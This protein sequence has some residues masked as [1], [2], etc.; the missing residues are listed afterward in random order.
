MSLTEYLYANKYRRALNDDSLKTYQKEKV[1]WNYRNY[2]KDRIRNGGKF[3][4]DLLKRI[5]EEHT[6]EWKRIKEVKTLGDI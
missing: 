1:F 3:N 2:V 4:K 6:K 5:C